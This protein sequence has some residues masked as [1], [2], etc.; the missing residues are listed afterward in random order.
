MPGTYES[1]YIK[2]YN[3]SVDYPDYETDRFK[4]Y[5]LGKGRA[6]ILDDDAIILTAGD[7]DTFPLW[8]LQDA[9]GLKPGVA[10]LNI[11]LLA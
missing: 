6:E 1:I 2:L 9:L 10:V 5:E 3:S 4:A 7:N 8:V 11:P